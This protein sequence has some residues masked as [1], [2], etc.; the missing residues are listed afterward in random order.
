LWEW[1]P[2]DLRNLRAIEILEH[3]DTADARSLLHAL[4]KGSPDARLT[5]AA[6][7]GLKTLQ[8]RQVALGKTEL[9]RPSIP[10]KEGVREYEAG[11]WVT[12]FNGKD[13]KDWQIS[14]KAEPFEVNENERAIMAGPSQPVSLLQTKKVYADFH[15]RFEFRIATKDANSGVNIRQPSNPSGK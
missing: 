6:A 5:R 12:L 4:A 11:D 1:P 15:L 8:W 14:G 9:S 3:V 13:L 2:E 10:I 7:A